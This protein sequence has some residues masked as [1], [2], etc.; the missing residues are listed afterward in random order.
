VLNTLIDQNET[1]ELIISLLFTVHQVHTINL[2][3]SN[4]FCNLNGNEIIT[5]GIASKLIIKVVVINVKH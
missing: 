4:W 2:N 3:M 5:G 1:K